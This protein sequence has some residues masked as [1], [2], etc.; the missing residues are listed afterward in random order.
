MKR[1]TIWQLALIRIGA[2]FGVLTSPILHKILQPFCCF[3]VPFA[4]ASMFDDQIAATFGKAI[5]A[6]LAVIALSW[7]IILMMGFLG[8]AHRF[9]TIGI[10]TLTVV[11]II[12]C[13][14]SCVMGGVTFLKVMNGIFSVVILWLSCLLLQRK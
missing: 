5:V 14:L 2:T 12:C 10:M 3:S 4:F 1:W 8:R 6:A 13:V 9:C 7:I 11:D